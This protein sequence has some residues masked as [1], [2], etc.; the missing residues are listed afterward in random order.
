[1]KVVF[2]FENVSVDVKKL[3]SIFDGIIVIKRLIR[4][5]IPYDT[6]SMKWPK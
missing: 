1:M 4:S 5:E 2:E 6:M 3:I